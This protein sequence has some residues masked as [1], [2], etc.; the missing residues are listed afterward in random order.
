MPLNFFEFL[1]HTVHLTHSRT[2]ALLLSDLGFLWPYESDLKSH[3]MSLYFWLQT[4][5]NWI[6]KWLTI[7]LN[8]LAQIITKLWAVKFSSQK[9]S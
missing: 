1:A 2:N 8:T 5:I 3:A 9:N 4:D 7:T 6:I